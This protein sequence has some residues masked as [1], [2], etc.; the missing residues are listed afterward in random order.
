MRDADFPQ[1][2]SRL[3]GRTRFW[4]LSELLTWGGAN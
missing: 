3:G 2:T 4:L 1:P